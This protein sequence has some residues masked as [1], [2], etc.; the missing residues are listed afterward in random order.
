MAT[1]KLY[2]E[3]TGVITTPVYKVS[4]EQK[5]QADTLSAEKIQKAREEAIPSILK[6]YEKRQKEL[7]GLKG[8][9]DVEEN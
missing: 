3:T 5:E 4:K 1:E 8:D 2:M 9:Q 6:R 7:L